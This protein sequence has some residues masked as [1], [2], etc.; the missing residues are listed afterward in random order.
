M[1]NQVKPEVPELNFPVLSQQLTVGPFAVPTIWKR[2]LL[3]YFLLA[4]FA[5]APYLPFCPK[6]LVD[7][8]HIDTAT[9]SPDYYTRPFPVEKIIVIGFFMITIFLSIFLI[10]TISWPAST[11]IYLDRIEL[12]NKSCGCRVLY[13][14]N[15]VRS[16]DG[17]PDV[18]MESVGSAKSSSTMIAFRYADNDQEIKN[19]YLYGNLHRE[20]QFDLSYIN[21]SEVRQ[22]FILALLVAQPNLKIDDDVWTMCEVNVES[23]KTDA[24][25]KLYEYFVYLFAMAVM[26]CMFFYFINKGGD[27]GGGFGDIALAM[28]VSFC[29]AVLLI[30]LARGHLLIDANDPQVVARRQDV[31]KKFIEKMGA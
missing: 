2:V 23:L 27:R 8:Y 19:R 7:W 9:H 18:W 20:R 31:L 4:L 30:R 11:R 12:E 10:E 17:R 1:Q 16:P 29:L 6:F 14:K 28:I 21:K 5:F 3:I 26:I 24:R 25:P 22:A 15:I 13:W